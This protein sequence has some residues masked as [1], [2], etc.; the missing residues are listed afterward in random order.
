MSKF[1]WTKML[2]MVLL[3]LVAGNILVSVVKS[4]AVTESLD[5]QSGLVLLFAFGFVG[6]FIWFAFRDPG[7]HRTR[8]MVI[9]LVWF[10]LLIGPGIAVVPYLNWGVL[11]SSVSV[12]T[13]LVLTVGIT[14]FAAWDMPDKLKE[15]HLA[16]KAQ[17]ADKPA[18][19]K[20][21]KVP[22]HTKSDDEEDGDGNVSVV[23]V[24]DDGDDAP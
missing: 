18:K 1:N 4:A 11:R 8:H 23:V 13:L 3:L 19:P 14:L 17:S 5:L 6:A 7:E 20:K 15:R 2:I 12:I 10:G 9:T 22:A 21:V 16:K 24:A